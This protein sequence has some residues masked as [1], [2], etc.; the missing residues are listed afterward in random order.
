MTLRVDEPDR[1]RGERPDA[2]G[3][4]AAGM[5]K[6]KI[7][8]AERRYKL[9]RRLVRGELYDRLF[10]RPWRRVKLW[11]WVNQFRP[12]TEVFW[13]ANEHLREEKLWMD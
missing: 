3:R 2:G 9:C 12:V 8:A 4:P 1:L 11:P 13:Q 6:E 7:L 5:S 10:D